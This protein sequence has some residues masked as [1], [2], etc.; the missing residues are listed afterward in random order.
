VKDRAELQVQLDA[1]FKSSQLVV[2]QA[3]VP[4]EFDWR[5]G[6]LAG[7]ALYACRYFMASGHWQIIQHREGARRRYGRVET[8]PVEWAPEEARRLAMKVATLIGDGLYGV[9]I[10][11]VDG[12]FIVIEVNDNPSIEAG[13]ED[14]ILKD[15]LYV[16]IMQHFRD[17]LDGRGARDGAVPERAYRLFEAFGVEIEY[18]I[19]DAA[20]LRR[21]GRRP[22]AVAR[23]RRADRRRRGVVERARAAR[24]RN[25]D[26]VRTGYIPSTASSNASMPACA[27]RTPDCS[28]RGDCCCP[29][30]CIPSSSR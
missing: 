25:E 18:M 23:R 20:T 19:V 10:K 7:R 17:R 16:A 26:A 4:S 28:E 27:K 22:S 12:R 1:F 6:V 15:G 29:A 24:A 5:I 3:F 14:E 9:D 8:L 11:E 21:A 13:V 2:A 30:A